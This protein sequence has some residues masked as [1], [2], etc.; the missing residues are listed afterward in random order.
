MKNDTLS[1]VHS[2]QSIVGSDI[3]GPK[4][5]F[6]VQHGRMPREKGQIEQIITKIH[7]F[8][9]LIGSKIIGI[10]CIAT[11]LLMFI[12][13]IVHIF[14]PHLFG[15]TYNT[16]T[17]TIVVIILVTLNIYLIL[18]NLIDIIYRSYPPE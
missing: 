14:Y 5:L 10:T 9:S 15:T 1:L 4:L 16:I 8:S 2:L 3:I 13:S 7:N 18:F 6:V 17:P 11:I 12:T